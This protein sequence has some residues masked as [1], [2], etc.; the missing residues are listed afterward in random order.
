MPQ[1][2]EGQGA[3][4]G[5]V[6]TYHIYQAPAV[7]QR[8]SANILTL[9]ASSTI[10]WLVLRHSALLTKADARDVITAAAIC[11]ILALPHSTHIALLHFMA[12][13]S[14]SG[15]LYYIMLKST[16]DDVC[17]TSQ[18]RRRLDLTSSIIMSLV[19]TTASCKAYHQISPIYFDTN[20]NKLLPFYIFYYK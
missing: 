19:P 16:R 4:T 3:V 10:G 7:I 18:R 20:Q 14:F 11:L 9:L 12:D 17:V 1:R 5:D 6:P 15:M 2:S 8:Q 13:L